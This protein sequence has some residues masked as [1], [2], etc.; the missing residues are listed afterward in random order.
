[1]FLSDTKPI[2]KSLKRLRDGHEV[3]WRKCIEDLSKRSPNWCRNLP[4]ELEDG[5]K[6][7][8]GLCSP[9]KICPALKEFVSCIRHTIDEWA[10]GIVDGCE[11]LSGLVKVS[12]KDVEGL[13]PARADTLLKGSEKLSPSS[14]LGGRFLG[15]LLLL[16]ECRDLLLSKTKSLHLLNRKLPS[17]NLQVVLHYICGKPTLLKRPV[18]VLRRLFGSDRP[19]LE[20]PHRLS[21]LDDTGLH[22]FVAHTHVSER[23]PVHQANGSG[24]ECLRKLICSSGGALC[25]SSRCSSFVRETLDHRSCVFDTNSSVREQT[26]ILSHVSEVVDGLVCVLVQLVKARCDLFETSSMPGGVCQDGLDRSHFE[27]VLLESGIDRLDR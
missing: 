6:S 27:L 14:N 16:L 20:R 24:R 26:N 9:A 10:D 17:L 15:G 22:V 13:G 18:K 7:F 5:R 23:A 8:Q 3:F 21:N 19:T 4:K 12:K 2:S 1:M 25:R 11:E